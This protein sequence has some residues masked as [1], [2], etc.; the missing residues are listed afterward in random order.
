MSLPSLKRDTA[1]THPSTCCVIQMTKKCVTK[2]LAGQALK[3]R[4]C[5]LRMP[6]P[7]SHNAYAGNCLSPGTGTCLNLCTRTH[8]YTCK[9]SCTCAVV[10]TWRASTFALS[11]SGSLVWPQRT[12]DWLVWQ[13]PGTF[14][15]P[16][17]SRLRVVLMCSCQ[18]RPTSPS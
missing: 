13:L 9:C 16:F 11:E 15:S 7:G 2:A 1:L 10:R 8:V 4:D 17:P 14:L 6:T 18:V 12:P 3:P 5:A